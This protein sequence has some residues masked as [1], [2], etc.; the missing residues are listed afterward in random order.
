MW[1]EWGL[2]LRGMGCDLSLGKPGASRN[3]QRLVR[4]DKLR[5]MRIMICGGNSEAGL[6][7]PYKETIVAATLLR[8]TK[9]GTDLVHWTAY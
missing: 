4:L 9:F 5:M 2:D 3:D 8:M 1:T 6:G 7:S